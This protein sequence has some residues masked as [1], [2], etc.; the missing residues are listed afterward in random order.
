MSHHSI[1]KNKSKKNPAAILSSLPSDPVLLIAVSAAQ[2]ITMTG[3][4]YI[5]CTVQDHMTPVRN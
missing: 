4:I 1:D 3:P 2:Y 5:T